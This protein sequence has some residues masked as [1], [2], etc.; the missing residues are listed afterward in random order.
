[1]Q[2]EYSI[3]ILFHAPTH[4]PQP[5]GLTVGKRDEYAESDQGTGREEDVH[6]RYSARSTAGYHSNVHHLPPTKIK[7][8]YTTYQNPWWTWIC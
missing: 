6:P 4:E 1:M 3:E 2:P 8:I 7:T 5:L